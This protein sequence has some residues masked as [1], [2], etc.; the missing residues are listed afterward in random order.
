MA[1]EEATDIEE[2]NKREKRADCYLFLDG[3]FVALDDHDFGE[4]IRFVH[5]HQYTLFSRGA[6]TEAV[7]F[8]IF[9]DISDSGF[10]HSAH[11][12]CWQKVSRVH[13]YVSV[14]WFHTNDGR[15]CRFRC[16]Q[17]DDL[18]GQVVVAHLFVPALS[19]LIVNRKM[20]GDSGVLPLQVVHNAF[21]FRI[22]QFVFDGVN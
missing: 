13:G 12:Q 7:L 9:L 5:V 1:T 22:S 21:V 2:Y 8:D 11:S 6:V 15:M 10:C 20:L 4:H 3:V 17:A 18:L 16:H 14:A 19:D